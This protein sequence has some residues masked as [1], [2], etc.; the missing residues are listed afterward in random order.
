MTVASI[1]EAVA[2]LDSCHEPR[3]DRPRGHRGDHHARYGNGNGIGITHE[4]WPASAIFA[5]M[6]ADPAL[7]A[8]SSGHANAAEY[9]ERT[10]GMTRPERG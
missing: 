3:C 1:C 5:D 8:A 6:R 10:R 9:L 4:F 7:S 2:S